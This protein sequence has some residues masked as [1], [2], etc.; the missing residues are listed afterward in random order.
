MPAPLDGRG[1]ARTSI[2]TQT[3]SGEHIVF[4]TG[5]LAARSLARVLGELTP[6]AFTWEIRVLGVAVAA[7]LT[8]D[9]IARRIGEL[10]GVSRV[11]VPGRCRGDLA[12]LS[13]RFGVPFERGP[14]ELKDMPAHFGARQRERDL[15]RHDCLIFAEIVDAPHLT[16]EAVVARARRYRE[17]G[18]DV[19]DVGCIPDMP[20][21]ALADCVRALKAE[22]FRVSVD[23]LDSEDLIAGARAGADYLF[24][25]HEDTLWIADEYPVTPILIGRNPHD[26]EAL[27]R[28]VRSF[29]TRGRPFFADA[30]LDP[31]HHGF[32]ASVL[33]YQTLRERFPDIAMLMG[34]GNLSEL[35]HAD[36]LGLNTLLMGIASELG[37][38]AVLTTEVSGHCRSVVREV[39]LAR[40][41]LHAA[42]EDGMPPRHID[43]GLMALHERKPFPWAA[44]EISDFATGVK[45]PNYRIQVAADGIHVYNR[46]GH[47]VA[48]DPYDLFPR[49]GVEEDGGHAFYLGM[50]LARAQ[51]AWQLGKRYEQD[52]ELGWGCVRPRVVT[53][54]IHFAAERSTLAARRARRR[55][56]AI[57]TE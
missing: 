54:Q 51:I 38:S 53:D 45:D 32:T 30:I 25:L 19:I 14:E 21:P 17:D 40:R 20:F 7:L 31:I 47:H 39:A 48:V 42:R 4:I 49:L 57:D 13:A 12:P 10:S 44:E 16:P 34:I 1:L 8:T 26:I 36:T 23:S 33:R 3:F 37:V 15:S 56:P 24:S 18:A 6:C 35:T 46:D 28:T 27:S 52:E 43:D 9:M 41:I 50:E 11:V 55:K 22:R 29:Q 2:M 5:K